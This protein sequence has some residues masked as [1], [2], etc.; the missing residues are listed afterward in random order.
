M[1]KVR[2]IFLHA[3][4][5]FFLLGAC[6]SETLLERAK[7]T[8]EFV[9]RDTREWV[10]REMSSHGYPQDFNKI[11]ERLHADANKG[12]VWAQYWLGEMYLFGFGVQADPVKR[13]KWHALAAEGG[14]VLSQYFLGL[15][16]LEGNSVPQD[17][18][19]A[20]EW[21]EKSAAQGFES[22][23]EQS[24]CLTPKPDLRKDGQGISGNGPFDKITPPTFLGMSA[25][26]DFIH[27]FGHWRSGCTNR[28]NRLGFLFLLSAA[29]AGH[30]KAQ[31][32]VGVAYH[33]GRGVAP[34]YENAAEWYG[35]A[36]KG[37]HR[38]ASRTYCK[39]FH[40]RFA[41]SETGSQA[42]SLCGQ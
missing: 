35:R 10:L 24:A 27:G 37:G 36:A 31:Y 25:K 28:N 2:L 38:G 12:D 19:K 5:S 11:A 32:L 8:V 17:H 23:R 34:D 39:H 1:L 6:A 3:L 21:F 7:A 40:D 26:D 29:K 20:L 16:Y 14:D 22:A 33:S 41:A 4:S 42:A 30:V 18:A 13:A 9:E 15:I